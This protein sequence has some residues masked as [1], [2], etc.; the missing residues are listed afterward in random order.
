ML[1]PGTRI[2][3]IARRVNNIMFYSDIIGTDRHVVWER[4]WRGI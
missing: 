4:D 1:Q 3:E 2:T